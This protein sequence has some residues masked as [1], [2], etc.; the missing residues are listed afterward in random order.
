MSATML[1]ARD[2]AENKTEFCP[3]GKVQKICKKTN[4]KPSDKV[5]HFSG[6]QNR[7]VIM[8]EKTILKGV[9][10]GMAFLES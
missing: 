5:K 10:A 7:D 4:K 9:G 6:E 1:G 2:I 3:T 8:S